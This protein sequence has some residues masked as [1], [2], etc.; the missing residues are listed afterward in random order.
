MKKRKS[1]GADCA[2]GAAGGIIA[3]YFNGTNATC[4][5][6][7]TF[8]VSVLTFQNDVLQQNNSKW[9]L[10][11][12]QLAAPFQAAGQRVNEWYRNVKT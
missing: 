12:Q 2:F 4:A 11:Y 1:G 3:S 10:C 6:R 7:I 8:P 9:K 5:L